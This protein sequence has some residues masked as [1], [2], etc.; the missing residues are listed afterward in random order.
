MVDK[1]L[2]AFREQKKLAE[3][4]G[5]DFKFEYWEWLQI[6]QDSGHLEERG[7]RKGQWVMSRYKDKGAY[8]TGNVRIV[9]AEI[10]NSEAGLLGWAPG[11][12]RRSVARQKRKVGRGEALTKE[13]S[14]ET[15]LEG[16]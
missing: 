1:L 13:R 8:E 5:I 16:S 2:K 3:L 4:R 6:W 12:H 10:N 7:R 14:G 9:R 11:G 15:F